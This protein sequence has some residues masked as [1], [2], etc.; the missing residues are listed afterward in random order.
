MRGTQI[1]ILTVLIVALAL[2]SLSIADNKT[3]A[4]R[5]FDRGVV[6]LEEHNYKVALNSFKAAYEASPHWAVL[7]HI[8]TCYAKLNRPVDA[9]RAFELFLETGGPDIPEEERSSAQKLL[10]E[11]RKKVGRLILLVDP[12]GTEVKIDGESVGTSPFDPILIKTGPHHI[13]AIRGS[14]SAEIGIDVHPQSEQ[15]IHMPAEG[16]AQIESTGSVPIAAPVTLPGPSPTTPTATP[17]TPPATADQQPDTTPEPPPSTTGILSVVANVPGAAATLDGK[18]IGE[19]PLEEPITPGVHK[20]DVNLRG[21]SPYSGSVRIRRNTK[22]S[23]DI[24]LLTEQEAADPVSGPY[25]AALSIAGVGL[26]G[27]GATLGFFIYYR[28]SQQNFYDILYDP[29]HDKYDERYES[30]TWEETCETADPDGFVGD[31]AKVKAFFCNTESQRQDYASF[32][33]TSLILA[34]TGGAVFATAGI[35]AVL[36]YKNPQWFGDES[37][38]TI[39]LQPMVTPQQSGLV[40]SGRF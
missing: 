40:L 22:S 29:S 6:A 35:F 16:G 4:R 8:G 36:F 10:D 25:I 19:L 14:E 9:I 18:P 20:L 21:Y 27:G 26:V 1:P 13:I 38:A 17:E 30:F 23:V 33:D 24:N 12:A 3:K 5:L 11:Q 32:R 34:V 37:E 39:K 15:T 31:D 7:A 28:N 2:P